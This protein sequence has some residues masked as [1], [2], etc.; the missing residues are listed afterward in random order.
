MKKEEQ[1][2]VIVNLSKYP[3][4]VENSSKRVFEYQSFYEKLMIML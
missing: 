2:Q 4:S 1:Y 3:E